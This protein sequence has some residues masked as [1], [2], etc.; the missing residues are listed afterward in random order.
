MNNLK[1]IVFGTLPLSTKVC[2]LLINNSNIHLVAVVL[3]KSKPVNIN[4]FEG[5]HLLKDFASIHKIKTITL[6]DLCSEFDDN[7][8]DYGITCRFN[9]ILK[10][11][12]LSK[13][14]YGVI[15]FHGGLLPEFGGLYSSCHSILEESK[16]GGGTIHF[17]DNGIDTG[18]IILRAEFE[19]TDFDTSES[20]FKKTQIYL[21]ES[22][23]DLL[24]KIINNSIPVTKQKEF[25]KKGYIKKYYNKDSINGLKK[26]N[27]T[28]D[29]NTIDKKVR[30][31][32][33]PL[34]EPAFFILNDKKYYV[35]T[36]FKK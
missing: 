30:A 13:F 29:I 12:H 24:P 23:V 34:F 32:D 3:G 36:N 6:D 4:T 27:L 7:Y 26:I 22:F 10:K 20:I 2:E 9:K 14:K 28:D 18:D 21:Y 19:I 25:I 5:T 33:F 11:E 16:K 35:R 17:I 1:M 8:F 15:N 31:F